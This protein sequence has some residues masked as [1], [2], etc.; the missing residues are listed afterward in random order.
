LPNGAKYGGNTGDTIRQMTVNGAPSRGGDVIWAD[1]DHD[2]KVTTNDRSVI[3]HAQP[4]WYGSWSNSITYKQW[5]FSFSLYGVFGNNIYNSSAWYNDAMSNSNTTPL[6]DYIYSNWRY[7][8]QITSYYAHVN[9]SGFNTQQ[10]NSK[11]V[12]DGSYIRLQSVSVG[13]NLPVK[14]CKR[15][16]MQSLRANLFASNLLTWTN[17]TGFDP[18]VNQTNVLTPGADPGTYPAHR[19]IGFVVNATF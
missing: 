1:L 2:G 5:T 15:V 10:V 3:G 6:P 16:F 7:P 14:W 19:E 8:G 4:K 9:G 18:A 12:E 13:Y 11:F 17:Y